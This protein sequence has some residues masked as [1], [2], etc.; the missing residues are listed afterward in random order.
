V[1][2][3]HAKHVLQGR[4]FVQQQLVQRSC[5]LLCEFEVSTAKFGSFDGALIVSD[6]LADAVDVPLGFHTVAAVA[7]TIGGFELAVEVGKPIIV[8]RTVTKHLAVL[9]AFGFAH[10][11]S[12]F[13]RYPKV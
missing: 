13:N 11:R 1:E 4:T 6:L 3:A 10:V 12:L 2:I 5:G 8:H 9:R 7:K